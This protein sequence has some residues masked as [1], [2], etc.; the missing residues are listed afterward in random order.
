MTNLK[1][2]LKTKYS[3]VR[4]DTYPEDAFIL[5]GNEMKDD[6]TAISEIYRRL[7]LDEYIPYANYNG[8]DELLS[9]D[10]WPERKSLKFYIKDSDVFLSQVDEGLID[11]LLGVFEHVS[12][13]WSD[14]K[15]SEGFIIY[16]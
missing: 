12:A 4:T 6:K 7:G 8:L 10:I 15:S 11:D 14:D 16:L 5:D 1:D 13:T 2:T 9:R 3:F